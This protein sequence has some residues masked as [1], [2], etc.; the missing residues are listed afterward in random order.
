MDLVLSS[1]DSFNRSNIDTMSTAWIFL[2]LAGLFEIGWPLGLKLAQAPG[3]AIAGTTIAIVC[4]GISGWFLFMAQ[5]TIPMGTAYAVWTGIGAAGT[6]VA[7]IV[8]HGDPSS[9]M[10]IFG[11][12]LIVGGVVTLKLAH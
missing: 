5:K 10:R 7:G 11:V 4:I 1:D 9:L 2:L 3:K 6:F 8:L 12:L